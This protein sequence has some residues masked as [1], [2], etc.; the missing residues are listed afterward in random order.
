MQGRELLVIHMVSQ[1]NGDQQ[2][3]SKGGEGKSEKSGYNTGAIQCHLL[4][5]Q[6]ALLIGLEDMESL[7]S[8]VSAV[9]GKLNNLFICFNSQK[10]FIFCIY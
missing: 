1:I 4:S 2:H 5:E 6:I 10:S 3:S 9:I 8:E 7:Y